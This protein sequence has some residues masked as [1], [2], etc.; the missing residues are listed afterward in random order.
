MRETYNSARRNAIL[1]LIKQEPGAFTAKEL[2]EKLQQAGREVALS[3]IYRALDTFTNAG[4]VMKN[5]DSE[6]QVFYLYTTECEQ[7][8][9]CFL[10]CS[11]CGAVEHVDCGVVSEL[12]RHIFEGHH[13]L[14]NH[15]KVVLSGICSKCNKMGDC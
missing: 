6:G 8:G 14:I 11:S 15:E 4:L 5:T 9:H 3:T 7:S 10:K 13:F 12:V 1:D 2:A